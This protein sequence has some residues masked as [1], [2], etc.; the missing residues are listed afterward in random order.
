M[1]RAARVD[2]TQAEIIAALRKVGASVQPLHTLGSGCPD[3][4]VGYRHVNYL[5]EIKD[6]ELPPSKRRLTADESTWMQTWNGQYAVA[7]SVREA[8]RIIGVWKHY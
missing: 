6:G 2:R 3:L 7:G 8:L 4:L 1:R 5:M